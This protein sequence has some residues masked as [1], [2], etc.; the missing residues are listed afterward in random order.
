MEQ[1]TVV[2]GVDG[3]EHSREAVRY[4]LADAARRGAALV[5]VRAFPPPGPPA[6]DRW[7]P[8]RQGVV[9]PSLS[10]I[11][12]NVEGQTRR[13]VRDL[14]EEVGGSATTVPV[15]ALGL[16]GPPATVLL[17][18]AG[19]ADLL[20]VGRRGRGAL[21]STVLGSVSLRCVLQAHCPVAVVPLPTDRPR[22]DRPVID[23]AS[24]RT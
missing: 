17:D 24:A 7:A 4:A 12:T 10:E 8:E 5:A 18:Q 2:V 23:A 19:H 21:A 11:T 15:E 6:D 3:S 9:P 20:V 22:T 1:A 16:V 14:A 13:L